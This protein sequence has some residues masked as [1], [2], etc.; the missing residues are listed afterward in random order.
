MSTEQIK[1]EEI[2]EYASVLA[3]S[4][5]YVFPRDGDFLEAPVQRD[6]KECCTD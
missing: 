4:G 6:I 5:V 1:N 2:E 3:I